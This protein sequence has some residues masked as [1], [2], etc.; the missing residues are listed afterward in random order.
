MIKK[1]SFRWPDVPIGLGRMPMASCG[2]FSPYSSG[3]KSELSR[4]GDGPIDG[5]RAKANAGPRHSDRLSDSGN[6]IRE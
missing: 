4:G 2:N 3:S 1:F 5:R 6:P